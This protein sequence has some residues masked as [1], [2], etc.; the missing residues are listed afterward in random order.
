MVH[1]LAC[2]HN[3]L[4]SGGTQLLVRVGLDLREFAATDNEERWRVGRQIQSAENQQEQGTIVTVFHRCLPGSSFPRCVTV[5]FQ[6]T[7]S[8]MAVECETICFREEWPGPG[9]AICTV[10]S[11]DALA[12]GAARS[13]P[14]N[15]RSF[16]PRLD[17]PVDLRVCS[18]R[19]ESLNAP[20]Q[21]VR[22]G[23]YSG[24]FLERTGR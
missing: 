4:I 18:R 5:K 8:E 9:R 2:P 10:E 11:R 20:E 7:E 24:I 21:R 19:H 1:S 16:D 15:C 17:L 3:R 12:K 23:S 13:S 22:T 14:R 6:S